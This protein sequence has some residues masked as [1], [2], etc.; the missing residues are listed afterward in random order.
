MIL[1]RWGLWI[2][3]IPCLLYNMRSVYIHRGHVYIHRK[4]IHL[5]TKWKLLSGERKILY[6]VAKISISKFVLLC[7]FLL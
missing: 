5:N 1:K 7:G 4:G 3:Y 2:F 6:A